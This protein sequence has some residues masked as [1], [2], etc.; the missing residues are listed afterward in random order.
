MQNFARHLLF[1]DGCL[2]I[3]AY[4]L[5]RVLVVICDFAYYDVLNSCPFH[6]V[7]VGC[8]L[9]FHLLSYQHWFSVFKEHD[10]HTFLIYRKVWLCRLVVVTEVYRLPVLPEDHRAS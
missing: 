7:Q 9:I 8:Y 6:Q 5:V 10:G 1:L 2:Q 3:I 4:T